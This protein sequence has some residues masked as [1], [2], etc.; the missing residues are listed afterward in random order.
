[1][2]LAAN[3][4]LRAKWTNE[5][6]DEWIRNVLKDRSDLKREKLERTRALMNEHA[7]DPLVTN[8]EYLIPNLHLPD[9]NDRHVLAAAIQANASV[10]VTFNLKDFPVR[11][12]S[13]YM[14]QAKHPDDFIM[15]LARMDLGMVLSAVKSIIA[16]LKNPPTNISQYLDILAK[17]GLLQTVDLLKEHQDY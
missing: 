9:P 16:R 12:L 6:H 5:I 13:K 17:L 1:M 15:L 14:V 2:R 8:Y 4:M 7:F 10:I 11:L 3:N